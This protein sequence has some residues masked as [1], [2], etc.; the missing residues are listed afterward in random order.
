[1][2]S[3]W[4]VYKPGEAYQFE[5]RTVQEEDRQFSVYV[6][7][8]PGVASYGRTVHAALLHITT[9]LTAAIES[10]HAAG[11]AIPLVEAEPLER[12]ELSHTVA[13]RMIDKAVDDG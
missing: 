8:L 1:M 2:D 10:Y 13:V 7:R 12:G 9:A 3:L 4:K 11:E 5:V 6:P